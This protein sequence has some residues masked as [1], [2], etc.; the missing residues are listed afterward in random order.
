MMKA[1]A[2]RL[3]LML[4]PTLLPALA[5][6]GEAVPTETTSQ[7]S[8]QIFSVAGGKDMDALKCTTPQRRKS[9]ERRPTPSQ[10][11]NR[12]QDPAPAG[13]EEEIIPLSE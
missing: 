9:P 13:S 3:L 8:H 12:K 10:G 11:D 1:K 7:A 2:L 5:V 4:A 6:S